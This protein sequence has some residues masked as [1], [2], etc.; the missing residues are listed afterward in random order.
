MKTNH[1]FNSKTK[2]L[3]IRFT[4]ESEQDRKDLQDSREA[5]YLIQ[6]YIGKHYP[7]H[8]PNQTI[9]DLS[10]IKENLFEVS[11]EIV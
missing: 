1:Q 5:D 2:T 8:S 4:A 6:S 9:K 11:V 3:T 7:N 10:E